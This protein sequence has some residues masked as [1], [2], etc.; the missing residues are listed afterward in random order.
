[1]WHSENKCIIGNNLW[2]KIPSPAPPPTIFDSILLEKY[3]DAIKIH[4]TIIM[5]RFTIPISTLKHLNIA[6]LMPIILVVSC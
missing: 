5:M 1:M 2:Q 6:F 3:S 4:M